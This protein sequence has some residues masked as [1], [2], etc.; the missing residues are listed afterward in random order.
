MDQNM[1]PAD[2][3]ALWEVV[4]ALWDCLGL[5]ACHWEKLGMANNILDFFLQ[6]P[7]HT[8]PKLAEI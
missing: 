4:G 1:D 6:K 2:I 7:D 5:G 8:L 3:Q